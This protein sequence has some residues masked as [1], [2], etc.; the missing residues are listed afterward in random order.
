MTDFDNPF[1]LNDTFVFG[2]SLLL[3][4]GRPRSQSEP[5]PDINTMMKENMPP[6]QGPPQSPLPQGPSLGP[7]LH[8]PP[9][10]KPTP[11]TVSSFLRGAPTSAGDIFTVAQ[12]REVKVPENAHLVKQYNLNALN[13]ICPGYGTWAAGNR[14]QIPLLIY[15]FFYEENTL[16]VLVIPLATMEVMEF[17]SFHS[18]LVHILQTNKA[19][20]SPEDQAAIS[21]LN[22]QLVNDFNGLHIRDNNNEHA[23]LKKY[24]WATVRDAKFNQSAQ[25][26]IRS[27]FLKET[28]TEPPPNYLPLHVDLLKS[29]NYRPNLTL[30]PCAD[31]RGCACRKVGEVFQYEKHIGKS[32]PNAYLTVDE[33]VKWIHSSITLPAKRYFAP[34]IRNMQTTLDLLRQP[35]KKKTKKKTTSGETLEP[36]EEPVGEPVVKPV[37]KPMKKPRKRKSVLRKSKRK[38]ANTATMLLRKRPCAKNSQRCRGSLIAAWSSCCQRPIICEYHYQRL[39]SKQTWCPQHKKLSK[40]CRVKC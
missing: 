10:Q 14:L 20:F 22:T 11:V 36:G 21:T 19:F 15:G 2:D 40:V 31:P 34:C 25:N 8:R 26:W 32:D 30:L 7:P 39:R 28:H 5:L 37:K 29:M 27:Q 4:P 9:L 6:P 1:T 24:I 33:V 18:D 16:K 3:E 17:T 23:L 38:R 12:N 35:K 13:S